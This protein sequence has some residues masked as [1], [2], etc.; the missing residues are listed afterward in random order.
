ME[1]IQLRR[2]TSERWA[3]VNPVLMEGEVGIATDTK[4]WKVGDGVNTW[5]NL[6]YGKAENILQEL[7]DSENATVS[8][9]TI[10]NTI[11]S[12]KGNGIT[13]RENS[14]Y[15]KDDLNYL[16]SV[17]NIDIYT[18]DGPYDYY[19]WQQ[20][21]IEEK[22]GNLI[23]Y[24]V[25]T[26]NPNIDNPEE[27]AYDANITL[28]EYSRIGIKTY[29]II[30]DYRNFK[31]ELTIDWDKYIELFED[32]FY[33][34]G[35]N[36]ALVVRSKVGIPDYTDFALLAVS[37]GYKYS[38]MY[39]PYSYKYIQCVSNV[40]LYT[41]TP[42]TYTVLQQGYNTTTGGCIFYFRNKDTDEVLEMSINK[43]SVPSG[44][45]HIRVIISNKALLELD[46]DW[47]LYFKY[48]PSDYY[49]D[50]HSNNKIEIKTVSL[51]EYRNAFPYN[52]NTAVARGFASESELIES[53]VNIADCFEKIKIE[54][55]DRSLTLYALQQGVNTS[56]TTFGFYF[57][58]H[59]KYTEE[60]AETFEFVVPRQGDTWKRGTGIEHI[61][62]NISKGNLIIDWN[63]DKYNKYFPT[64]MYRTGSYNE[65]LIIQTLPITSKQE[66][67]SEYFS[68]GSNIVARPNNKI[69]LVGASFASPGNG[70]FELACHKLGLTAVNRA[71]GGQSIISNVAERM[72]DA[73]ETML[74][75]SLFYVDGKD[76]FEEVKA[77][78]IMMTHNNDVYLSDKEYEQYSLDYYHTNG[79]GTNVKM[80]WDYVIK[81]YKQWCA[82]YTITQHR[83]QGE[84]EV[85]DILGTKEC[86]ILI[87][88]NWNY[89][90][91]LYN[92]SSRKLAKRF[93]L[94]YCAFDENI[95]LGKES[96]VEATLNTDDNLVPTLG[97][98]HQSIL[99]SHFDSFYQ[100]AWAGKTQ[101]ING[102]LYGWHPQTR[103]SSFDYGNGKEDDGYYYPNIQY[104]LAGDFMKCITVIN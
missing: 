102:I 70:W 40:K 94:S 55:Y 85:D 32:E 7:G 98:Y 50:S 46:I 41:L 93:G 24:F 67:S 29:S 68:L 103:S 8:Q 99:Y 12:N 60:G 84:Q 59:R 4:T 78:V 31:V 51:Q 57:C 49:R 30:S 92:D 44:N 104:I 52:V 14:N 66:D 19:L 48:F 18:L 63:W 33:R 77:F 43:S 81:Q 74:H 61:E 73:D 11:Y 95:S 83:A 62:V 6:E 35:V 75:G 17:V 65:R 38:S 82:E 45:E 80:A 79:V 34:G 25:K 89:G 16:A 20:G 101:N 28:S 39:S 100:G 86:Q 88:S 9:K 87:C 23:F 69:V 72:L 42:G 56:A 54:T 27:L 21:A 37:K 90:R 26:N 91:T 13:L 2:D 5:N 71:I 10:A 64:D 97:I 96:F 36:R 58:T 1:R 15:N 22:S 47:D 3:S 76:I 53:T